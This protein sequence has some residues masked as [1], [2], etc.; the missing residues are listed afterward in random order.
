[1]KKFKQKLIDFALSSKEFKE[2]LHV[3][4]E[5]IV[6]LAASAPNEATIEG[7]FE[8]I[9]YSLL[10]DIG[11]KFHPQKEETINTKRHTS[12]G[13]M[14]SRIGALVIEYKHNSRLRSQRD[15]ISAIEQIG[16]YLASLSRTSNSEITG[17]VTD[18]IHLYELKAMDGKTTGPSG[19]CKLDER[20]LLRII[21]S[22]VA[23]EQA[24]LTA[25]NIV[26]DFCGI[27]YEGALFDLAGILNTMLK[28]QASP[29]TAMLMAEWEALFKLAHEDQSQQKRIQERRSV[30]AIIFKNKLEDAS[31]EYRTL[32]ALHTAYAI[33]LKFIAY[34]VVAELQFGEPL[35]NYKAMI[36]ADSRDLLSFC[37]ELEDGEIFR[38]LGILNLLEG[39]FFSWYADKGQWNDELA[40][41]LQN[42]LEILGRYESVSR[43]FSEKE[44][45]DLFRK[46][47][48]ATVPQVIRASF[49]EFYT[50]FW[51]AQHVINTSEVKPGWRMLDPCCGS[52]T[53]VIAAISRQRKQMKH[54][55]A[56]QKLS[57]ILGRVAAFDLNPLAVLT[58]R[59][60]YFI[61][62]SDLLSPG[63]ANLVIPVFLGDSSYVPLEVDVDGVRCLRYELRTLRDPI[64]AEL[65]KSLVEKTPQFVQLMYQYEKYVKEKK[66]ASAADLLINALDVTERRP[67]VVEKIKLLTDRLVE[68]EKKKWNGIWARILTNFLTTAC[69]GKFSNIVGNPPWIDWKNLPSGY[70]DKIKDTLPDKGL[71]SGAGRTGGINLNICALITHVVATTWLSDDGRL[72]FLMPKELVNQA[73]YEGWRKAVG[74]VDKD[75]L[76]LFDWSKAGHPFDP[77]KEDFMTYIIGQRALQKGSHLGSFKTAPI[78]QYIKKKGHK[79]AAHSWADI[80]EAMLHL[81]QREMVAGQV[82]PGSTIY[83]FARNE[84]H[85]KKFKKIAG[86]SSYKGREGIEF[87]PQEL[88]IFKYVGEGKG[89][90]KGRVFLRNIQV[91]KSKYKIF[92]QKT[93]LETKFL[94]PLVKSTSIDRFSHEW[95]GHIVPFPYK[96]N[97]PRCPLDRSALRK[98]ATLLLDYYERHEDVVRQQTHFSDKIRGNNA[99]EFYGLARTGPYSFQDIYVAFRDNTKWCASVITTQ[100]MPW[101]EKKRFVFQNHAVSMCERADGSGYIDIEEAHYICAILNTPIVAEFINASSDARSFK[102]RPPIYI[103]KY[104]KANEKHVRLSRISQAL[105]RSK[106]NL[107]GALHEIEEI[108]L[109]L[110]SRRK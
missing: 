81:D 58:T 105:H 107:E 82:I 39:D 61:H 10:K 101:H 49:G 37:S 79:S 19:R 48:E 83:T 63:M 28:T 70:R 92:E 98:E 78:V 34:R 73:S 35:K 31:S 40:R 11:I 47:Y 59:I 16:E 6:S 80:N 62:I 84:A 3:V 96:S 109:S 104:Q 46:L 14:D 15:I 2:E 44:A 87:Y 53:F 7:I 76:A 93:L 106:D 71:F 55:T 64:L 42:V 24:A 38:K 4:T 86:E 75:I 77:V 60:H 17:F 8:R 67:V 72:A 23:L 95:E 9:L 66:A 56:E 25:E 103:P 91:T 102:I 94:Y 100:T 1:M 43:I 89:A 88:V 54:L 74:G 22:I 69:L 108:Y 33:V 57:Q 90:A 36:A 27:S 50:P 41:A 65:P 110:C 45:V 18:G 5:E 29:K 13:R 99:G 21:K 32:F 97:D 30:L 68:L 20:S 85:L 26:R 12:K 52:G 51:L